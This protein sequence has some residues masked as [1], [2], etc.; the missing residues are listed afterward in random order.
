MV[1]VRA[2]CNGYVQLILFEKLFGIDE[3]APLTVWV[4]VRHGQHVLVGETLASLSIRSS[5]HLLED[6]RLELIADRLRSAFVLGSERTFESDIAYGLQQI[7][8]IAVKA[9]SPGIND[10]TTALH[11]IDRLSELLTDLAARPSLAGAWTTSDSRVTLAMDSDT[12]AEMLEIAF[13]Q[14]RHYGASDVQVSCHLLDVL[15][16]IEGIA[17]PHQREPLRRFSQTVTAATLAVN[18]LPDSRTRIAASSAW[19]RTS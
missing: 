11:C 19:L 10:P 9:L 3:N 18:D 7:S 8:D 12:Y 16:R 17:P 4:Q 5:S 6:S 14:I 13:G 15:M 1:H 2:D